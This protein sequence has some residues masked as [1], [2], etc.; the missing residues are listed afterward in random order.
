MLRYEEESSE[1]PP[2]DKAAGRRRTALSQGSALLLVVQSRVV[3]L[4]TIHTPTTDSAG[5]VYTHT[6]ICKDNKKKAINLN[7]GEM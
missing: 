5:C 2:L 1:V 7:V 6:H 3:N 4:K